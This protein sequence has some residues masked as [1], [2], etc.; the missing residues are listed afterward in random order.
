VQ[1]FNIVGPKRESF[2][3]WHA[4]WYGRIGSVVV[5]TTEISRIEGYWTKIMS[6]NGPFEKETTIGFK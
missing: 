4:H 2:D 1:P 5:S 6:S 3:D